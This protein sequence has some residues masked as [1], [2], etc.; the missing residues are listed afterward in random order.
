MADGANSIVKPEEVKQSGRWKLGDWTKNYWK[1]ECE[2]HFADP[3]S[4]APMDGSV[5][6]GTGRVDRVVGGRL[7]ADGMADV[8]R[9]TDVG[10][11]SDQQPSEEESKEESQRQRPEKGKETR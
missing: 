3:E 8:N 2:A 6:G 11:E 4:V 10:G 9:E 5:S 1:D 7:V